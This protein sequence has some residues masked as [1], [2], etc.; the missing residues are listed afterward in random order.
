MVVKFKLK[1]K[2]RFKFKLKFNFFQ[3]YSKFSRDVLG[4]RHKYA[5]S[6]AITIFSSCFGIVGYEA[7]V[8][9]TIFTSCFSIVGYEAHTFMTFSHIHHR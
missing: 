4:K 1:F 9:I 5:Q 7:S 6:V 2:F 8:A 3:I